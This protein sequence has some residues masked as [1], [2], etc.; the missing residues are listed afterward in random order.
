MDSLDAASNWGYWKYCH[1][2]ELS[3]HHMPGSARDHLTAS[4][5]PSCQ[6]H[7][8]ALCDASV[9]CVLPGQRSRPGWS[10]QATA[11]N[12]T[13]VGSAR[14]TEVRVENGSKT[15]TGPQRPGP[16][17]PP[18]QGGRCGVTPQGKLDNL[19]PESLASTRAGP[20]DTSLGLICLFCLPRPAGSPCKESVAQAPEPPAGRQ[21]L[22]VK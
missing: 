1:S 17:S 7:K 4:D 16:H 12:G 14:A 18:E 11:D 6:G 5:K 20:T 21:A 9:A 22:A 2:T 15:P 8:A 13:T 19:N 3:A 10:A